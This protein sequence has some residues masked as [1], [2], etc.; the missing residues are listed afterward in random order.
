MYSGKPWNEV[1]SYRVSLLAKMNARATSY[2][3]VRCSSND[4]YALF[5]MDEQCDLLRTTLRS[6]GLPEYA[7]TCTLPNCFWLVNLEC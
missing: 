1:G 4:C 2:R 3:P 5:M 6:W 7:R